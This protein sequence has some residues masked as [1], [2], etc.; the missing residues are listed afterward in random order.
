MRALV[1][2]TCALAVALTG[3]A[4]AEA[5]K[6]RKARAKCAKV[7]V[8][9][10][11]KGKKVKVCRRKKPTRR[12]PARTQAAPVA[13]VA[14]PPLLAPATASSP[15]AAEPAP[16]AAPGDAP[17]Q[18]P[19]P[20]A[21]ACDPSNRLGVWAEDLDGRF[22]FTLT[23]T[24]VPAGLVRVQL[25]NRDLQ[26]HNVFVEGVAPAA[27]PRKVVDDV[28]GSDPKRRTGDGQV[29]LAPGSWRFFCAIE[30]HESMTATVTATG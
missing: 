21:P 20:A 8:K 7:V 4:P 19:V 25:V 30:G 18:A 5:G 10:T 15:A 24:C 28:D 1:A 26:P 17:A 14:A 3:A 22:I 6:P 16:P 9:R 13:P 29:E 2:M 27:A 11:A 12:T 23:R